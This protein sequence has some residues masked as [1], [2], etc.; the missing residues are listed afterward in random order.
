MT[1][2]RAAFTVLEII[3]SISI[4]AMLM[5]LVYKMNVFSTQKTMTGKMVL[6]MDS[7][8]TANRLMYELRR[9][10]DFVRPHLGE[11]TTYLLAKD[12]TNQMLFIYLD[13]DEESSKACRKDLYK[14][15]LYRD[16]HRG[17]Y[18]SGEEKVIMKSVQRLTFTCLD[19]NTV[20]LNLIM[21]ND[22]EEYQIITR[23]GAMNLGDLE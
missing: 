18:D 7:L 11:T 10:S 5:T 21:A 4:L 8:R 9:C 15:V 6:Q 13:K 2:K 17:G 16:T 14:I 20:Q 3:I 12:M 22:T 1:D 19:P 23:V